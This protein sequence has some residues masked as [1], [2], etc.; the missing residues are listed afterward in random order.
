M[1]DEGWRKIGSTDARRF[2]SSTIFH[3]SILF[4]ASSPCL[5]VSVVQLRH[6]DERVRRQRCRRPATRRVA[7]GARARRAGGRGCSRRRWRRAC[8]RPWW[9]SPREW[10]LRRNLRQAADHARL[11]SARLAGDERFLGVKLGETGDD[12]GSMYVAGFVVGDAPAAELRRL[13]DRR[14]PPAGQRDPGTSAPFGV[15]D[16]GR[17]LGQVPPPPT[18]SPATAP[19]GIEPRRHGDT[20]A[21]GGSEG[22]GWKIEDRGRRRSGCRES[23]SPPILHPPSSIFVF[24]SYLRVSVVQF[25]PVASLRHV[26]LPRNAELVVERAAADAFGGGRGAVRRCDAGRRGCGRAGPPRASARAGGGDIG[27]RPGGRRRGRR[28]AR[29]P[30][31]ASGRAAASSGRARSI[32]PSGRVW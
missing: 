9:S 23:V 13:P 30:P 2:T 24:S 18:T 16:V 4:S 22:G 3:P 17:V 31:A 7:R 28:T 21:G 25:L 5:R 10:S 19:G 14:L 27:G 11:L 26:T 32:S 1:E 15:N 6:P 29:R 20:E 12:G 8:W